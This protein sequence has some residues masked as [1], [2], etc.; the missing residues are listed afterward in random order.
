MV[1]VPPPHILARIVTPDDMMQIGLE[2]GG[3][4]ERQI[5]RAGLPLRYNRFK[6]W[7]GSHPVVCAQIWEDLLTTDIIEARIRPTD[8]LDHFLMALFF[9]KTYCTEHHRSGIFKLSEKSVRKGTWYFVGKMSA[10]KGL[11]VSF[12]Q[13]TPFLDHG[14]N[15]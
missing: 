8:D 3:Y 2:H 11:K 9:L 4:S 12:A 6:S 1:A 10:L 14:D 13:A 5:N 7:F 15:L